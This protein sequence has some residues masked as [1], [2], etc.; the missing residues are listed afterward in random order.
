[1]NAKN[2]VSKKLCCSYIVSN[3]K[4]NLNKDN[5]LYEVL[6]PDENKYFTLYLD[7]IT[8]MKRY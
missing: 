1:V 2:L 7:M 6:Y 3:E 4:L 8:L 5:N